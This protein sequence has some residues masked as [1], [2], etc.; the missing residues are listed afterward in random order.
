MTLKPYHVS[1]YNTAKASARAS[2]SVPM[3]GMRPSGSRY[4]GNSVRAE[5]GASKACAACA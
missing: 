5:F 2:L 1:A 3:T 4:C